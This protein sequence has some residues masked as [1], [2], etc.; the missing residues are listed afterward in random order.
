LRPAIPV[1]LEE[2]D[3][4]Q[5]TAEDLVMSWGYV[6]WSWVAWSEGGVAYFWIDAIAGGV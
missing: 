1:E 2:P 3:A 5:A 6:S 4:S